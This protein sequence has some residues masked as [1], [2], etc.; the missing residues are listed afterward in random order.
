MHGGVAVQVGD[1]G[2][3]ETVVGITA[4]GRAR[5]MLFRRC[6]TACFR[7]VYAGVHSTAASTTL[8]PRRVRW[9]AA[10]VDAGPVAR[11][12][13]RRALE[14]RTGRRGRTCTACCGTGTSASAS[15][16]TST[17]VLTAAVAA[18]S[19]AT[20]VAAAR[21]V[22]AGVLAAVLLLATTSPVELLGRLIQDLLEHSR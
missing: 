10:S 8:R 7:S 17:V 15:G 14:A 16:G 9:G 13:A 5:L 2:V 12:R 21:V 3:E 11:R 19:T 22:A 4:A 20:V 18:A 1:P 6:G